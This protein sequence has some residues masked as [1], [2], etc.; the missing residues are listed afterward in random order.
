MVPVGRLVLLRSIAKSDLVSAMAYLT[1][2]ALIG[3]VAGTAARG[4]H[5]H[6]FPLALDLLDQCADRRARPP[7]FA[8]VHPQFARGGGAALRLPGIRPVGRWPREPD[9]R[10][11]RDR[12]RRCASLARRGDDHGRAHCACSLR[13]ARR[14]KRGRDPRSQAALDPDF[15]RRRRRRVH[16]PHR[17]RRHTLPAA[18]LAADRLRSQPVRLGLDHLRRRGGRADD[19]IHRHP[20][21]CAGSASA[22]R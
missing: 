2:P 22:R 10:L 11:E 19:E 5:H 12:A 20:P 18:A 9:R 3:P 7:A 15:F 13:P 14:E 4:L 8:Q 6:L 1:V 17:R 16:L 21:R